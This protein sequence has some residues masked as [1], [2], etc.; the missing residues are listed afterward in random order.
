MIACKP[1][2]IRIRL[3]VKAEAD[4]VQVAQPIVP[5]VVI[6]PP[7]IGLVVEIVLTEPEP[8]GT[9]HVPSPRQK[10]V[11]LAEVPEF[12]LAT[13]KLPVTPPLAVEARLIGRM[14][15]ATKDLKVGVA[16]APV[17]GPAR[18]RFAL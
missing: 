11:A 17:V 15:A 10:V 14:S 4:V 13:G 16:A 18:I 6:G 5:V 2:P 9:A 7:V 8:P 12:N 3:A 1:L